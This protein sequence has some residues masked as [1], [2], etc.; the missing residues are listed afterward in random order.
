MRRW[1][2]GLLVGGSL[3]P[4]LMLF[5][6]DG[7]RKAEK[8]KAEKGKGE[9]GKAEGETPSVE[10]IARAVFKAADARKRGTLNE[11][12]ANQALQVLNARLQQYVLAGGMM[13]QRGGF[14][15][16]RGEGKGEPGNA[17][18]K[19]KFGLKGEPSKKGE[20]AKGE[21]PE[22]GKRGKRGDDAE[23]GQTKL[24]QDGDKKV[25]EQEF[26]AYADVLANHFAD[27]AR[28]MLAQQGGRMQ[29]KAGA[30]GQKGG[31]QGQKG[32]QPG[33]KGGFKGKGF[34]G[35]GGADN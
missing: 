16:K 23:Q 5:A 35:K 13:R 30:G 10:D 4:C 22:K 25:S 24:D 9:R 27:R 33:Q 17:G 12:Q 31:Q 34:A 20:V 2:F 6:A 3:I 21:R 7:D 1:F 28:Q 26:V 14:A 15:G 29:G 8:G 11:Q 18:E 19:G 32:G